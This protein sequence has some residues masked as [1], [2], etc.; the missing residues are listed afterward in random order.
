M[1]EFEDGFDGVNFPRL[2]TSWR[3]LHTARWFA[4]ANNLQELFVHAVLFLILDHGVLLIISISG[5]KIIISNVLLDT[6]LHHSFQS[7]ISGPNFF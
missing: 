1:K 4:I 2:L 7:V 6:S 5:P 3:K